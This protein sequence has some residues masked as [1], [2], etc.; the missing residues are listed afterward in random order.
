MPG[1]AKV[2]TR[3]QMQKND[4]EQAEQQRLLNERK[5]LMERERA[6]RQRMLRERAAQ[7]AALAELL[8]KTER[9]PYRRR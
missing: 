1:G 3:F 5:E 2:L 7:R 8:P 9:R 4:F 6:E